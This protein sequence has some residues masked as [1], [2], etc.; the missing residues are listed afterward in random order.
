MTA[1]VTTYSGTSYDVV[2]NASYNKLGDLTIYQPSTESNK[3]TLTLMLDKSGSM[4]GGYSFQDDEPGY[5][6]KN[7]FRAYTCNDWYCD[8]RTNYYYLDRQDIPSN[9]TYDRNVRFYTVDG[10]KG[11]NKQACIVDDGNGS[12]PAALYNPLY[13]TKN[14]VQLEYCLKDN[15]KVYD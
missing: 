6:I 13:E 3:P 2:G 7:M 10:L 8:S 1:S 14:G 9:Q 4:G 12:A 11:K 15:K 5:G